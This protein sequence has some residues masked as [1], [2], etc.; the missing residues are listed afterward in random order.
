[1]RDEDKFVHDNE[2]YSN[3]GI[4]G[5]HCPGPEREEQ[6]LTV[7]SVLHFLMHL[8]LCDE[9]NV[10]LDE[11]MGHVTALVTCATL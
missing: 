8:T 4:N 10:V 5:E 11:F 3:K 9:V 1:M 6:V 7:L 2:F